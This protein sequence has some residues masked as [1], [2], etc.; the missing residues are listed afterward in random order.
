ML[1]VVS[2]TIC[3]FVQRLTAMLELKQIPYEVEY[4]QLS[5]KPEW[6]LDISPH[7]QVPVLITENGQ[8]LFE[9]DAIVEYIEDAYGRL[10]P[11]IS[12]EK[13]A[14]QRAWAYLATKNYLVQCSA[15][16]SATAEVLNERSL[17][18]EKALKAVEK[19]LGDGPF[20]DGDNIS[21]VDVAWLVILHR[22]AIIEKH[23]GYDFLAGYPK[24]KR[25]QQALLASDVVEKSVAADFEEKF[26]NFYLSSETF[27][28]NCGDACESGADAA[29]ATASCC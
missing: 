18:L 6:F 13:R 4:I 12:S 24:L 15:Q 1:K 8:P 14:V 22:A 21:I 11:E 7:G 29:C 5:D 2:F 9:S 28:G 27:L 23:N 19:Q 16:R 10:Q 25:W 20:F 3:P 17:K 26:V